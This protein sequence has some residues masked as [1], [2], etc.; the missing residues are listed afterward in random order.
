[1][2]LFQKNST[3]P[4]ATCPPTSDSV[5]DTKPLPIKK[6]LICTVAIFLTINSESMCVSRQEV[7][8]SHSTKKTT[9]QGMD[10][11][12][13][14]VHIYCSPWG[15]RFKMLTQLGCLWTVSTSIFH[16][17]YLC[18]GK[19]CAGKVTSISTLVKTNKPPCYFAECHIWV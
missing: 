14:E 12:G 1:M 16:C 8:F 15:G 18:L 10:M 7:L 19:I 6:R 3:R 13:Q 2:L 5:A 9:T 11:P 17:N 4:F